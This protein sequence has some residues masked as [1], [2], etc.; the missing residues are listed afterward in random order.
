MNYNY[1]VVEL[2]CIKVNSWSCLKNFCNQIHSD[3]IN[4]RKD[5]LVTPILAYVATLLWQNGTLN[6]RRCLRC[7]DLITGE[8]EFDFRFHQALW[9]KCCPWKSVWLKQIQKLY[10][11]LNQSQNIY[12]IK[13]NIFSK[14]IQLLALKMSYHGMHGIM[15]FTK[16]WMKKPTFTSELLLLDMVAINPCHNNIGMCMKWSLWICSL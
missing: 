9:L 12:Q 2:F 6:D 15:L 7:W 11:S 16:A 4:G 8:I 13:E 14:C 1:H 10:L 5:H 3:T